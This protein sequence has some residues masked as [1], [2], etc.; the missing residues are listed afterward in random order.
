MTFF[1][2]GKCDCRPDFYS[3][4]VCRR[5]VFHPRH[6]SW[7]PPAHSLP[8]FGLSQTGKANLEALCC[9][10]K[11]HKMKEACISESLLGDHEFSFC[12]KPMQLMTST[13]LLNSAYINGFL[14]MCLLPCVF[15]SYLKSQSPWLNGKHVEDFCFVSYH[16]LFRVQ[17]YWNAQYVYWSVGELIPNKTKGKFYQINKFGCEKKKDENVSCSIVSDSLQPHGL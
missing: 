8:S 5:N 17:H 11:N 16:S 7:K 3:T 1:Y 4:D 12:M 14:P 15:L 10:G 13:E 6:S 9:R 2:P